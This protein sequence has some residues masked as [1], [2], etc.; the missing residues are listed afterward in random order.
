MKEKYLNH[1]VFVKSVVV[2]PLMCFF[3]FPTGFFEYYWEQ[4]TRCAH[5][6][7]WFEEVILDPLILEKQEKFQ[8]LSNVSIFNS[9]FIS[10]FHQYV[11]QAVA[12]SNLAKS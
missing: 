6:D 11:N 9:M 3:L 7:F 1:L 10:I 8:S 4:I 5:S 12:E 2:L